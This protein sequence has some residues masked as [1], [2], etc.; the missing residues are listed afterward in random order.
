[1]ETAAGQEEEDRRREIKSGVFKISVLSFG[2]HACARA[3]VG[4]GLVPC[5]EVCAAA[6]PRRPSPRATPS[7]TCACVC[8]RGLRRALLQGRRCGRPL[9]AE[10]T[11]SARPRSTTVAGPR[12]TTTQWPTPWW[13]CLGA[14]WRRQTTR[15]FWRS[16]ASVWLQPTSSGKS[17][18]WVWA[19]ARQ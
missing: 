14:R 5:C 16:F 9:P 3:W 10:S 19:W 1:M 18:G 6:Q 13:I 7:S 12:R 11:A 15:F 8:R 4:R 2:A 17:P